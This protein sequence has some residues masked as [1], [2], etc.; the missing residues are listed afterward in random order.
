MEHVKIQIISLKNK[1]FIVCC[2]ILV[3]FYVKFYPL[4]FER[5][6]VCSVS[7]LFIIV[8]VTLYELK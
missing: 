4:N 7:A 5:I 2:M 3:Y 1:R 8:P 6:V